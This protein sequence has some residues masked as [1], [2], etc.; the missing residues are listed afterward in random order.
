MH[1]K[2]WEKQ[3]IEW[4]LAGKNYKELGEIQTKSLELDGISFRVQFNPNRIQSTTANVSQAVI[5]ERPCFLCDF[6]RPAEQ[7][8]LTFE[9]FHILVNPFPV[10]PMHF[11]LA[12]KHTP[13]R[14]HGQFGTFLKLAGQLNDCVVFYNGPKCGASAPDHMHFQAGNKG[15]L[16]LEY[17]L[18]QWKLNNT[19]P[20]YSNGTIKLYQLKELF[21]N[22]WLLE[23]TDKTALETVFEQLLSSLRKFAQIGQSEPMLNLIGWHENDGWKCLIFPRKAHRPSCYFKEKDEQIL[24]SPASVEMGGVIVTSRDEDFERLD[25]MALKKILEEVTLD[26]TLSTMVS[27]HFL[28]NFK[29][30]LLEVGIVS[31]QEIPFIF[32]EPYRLSGEGNPEKHYQGNYMARRNGEAIVFEGK[33]FEVLQFEPIEPDKSRFELPE[34]KIGIGFHWERTEHQVFEGK[35]KILKE[36]E[37]LTAVNRIPLE[38]YLTSVISSEMSAK[39]STELLK[40]HAVISRSWLLSQ[41]RQKDKKAALCPEYIETETERIRWYDREDHLL[42]D[43]C[44]D[45]HCQRYQGITKASTPQVR[46]AI[47]TTKGQVLT[48]ED[49]ICDARFSKCCGGAMETFENCWENSPKPYL[50]GLADR[51]LKKLTSSAEIDTSSATKSST[52]NELVELPDLKN[53]EASRQWILGSPPAFCHTRDRHILEQV[54][55]NYDQETVDFYRWKVDYTTSEISQIVKQRSGIDFGEIQNLIPVERGVSGRLVR[56][57]IVGSKKTMILGKELEIRR[58]LS[59]SHLYS[60]AFVVEKTTDGFILHGAGW[61]HGVGLCQIGAAVMSEEGYGYEAILNHYYPHTQL[62]NLYL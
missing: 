16:P 3:L 1:H 24:V 6:N 58:T 46:S 21:R 43:V 42:Y 25:Q 47:S 53:E 10:F 14:I 12:G 35:L 26:E 54:L 5:T 40:A 45:D 32:L 8:S 44:A 2:L 38:S 15:F 59:T 50:Q 39:A 31:S 9:D 36:G 48:Y 4:P 11:T 19:N 18:K 49:E 33:E 34:V 30:P 52:Q 41:I 23:G 37:G 7:N 62:T 55:N 29:E 13:Q 57:Q 22:G 17:D 51:T 27:N 60:S 28:E 20:I 61:G 56:L